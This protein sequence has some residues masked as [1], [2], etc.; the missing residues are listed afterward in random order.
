MKIQTYTMVE[1][2]DKLQT[3]NPFLTLGD[4]MMVFMLVKTL[5]TLWRFPN[6]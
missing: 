6:G 3:L 1:Y 4:A 5:I 2:F